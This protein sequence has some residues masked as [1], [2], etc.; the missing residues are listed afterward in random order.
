MLDSV[1]RCKLVVS[2]RD[3]LWALFHNFSV[4]E[5]SKLCIECHHKLGIE[6]HEIFWQLLM[7]RQFHKQIVSAL[8]KQ[9]S[10]SHDKSDSRSLTF[11]EESAIRY[12]AGAVLRKVKKKYTKKRTQDLECVAL[13]DDMTSKISSGDKLTTN[14]R[15]SKWTKLVDRGAWIVP[16]RR[17]CVSFV[18]STRAHYRQRIDNHLQSERT[19]Y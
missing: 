2:K 10:F 9:D 14:H 8:N 18:C 11:I 7:E 19:R 15:S 5:G 4:D 1:K 13:I 12:T 6:A 17:Y 3:R 16:R